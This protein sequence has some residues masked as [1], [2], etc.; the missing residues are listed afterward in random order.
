MSY[1]HPVQVSS[2]T[3]IVLIRTSVFLNQSRLHRPVNV[4]ASISRCPSKTNTVFD[5]L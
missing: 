2:T 1:Y 5:D 4:F 3:A